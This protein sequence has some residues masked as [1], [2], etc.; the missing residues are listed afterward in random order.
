MKTEIRLA[1]ATEIQSLR[2]LVLWPHK[3]FEEC[4]LESDFHPET[5]HVASFYNGQCVGTSTWQNEC[6]DKWAKKNVFRLRAMAV[7]LDFRRLGIGDKL[8]Q[9]GINRCKESG[10]QGVWC[11]ARIGAVDFYSE[12]N[13]K[14]MGDLYFVANIGWHK[15]M[16]IELE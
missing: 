13:F 4:V 1:H 6:S 5:F 2:K 14:V 9:H 7:H 3:S 16:Y 12:L 10:V 11:D 8:I 15:F